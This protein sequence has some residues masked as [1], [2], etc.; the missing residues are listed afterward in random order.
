ML[1]EYSTQ[2]IL[3]GVAFVLL[4]VLG[5]YWYINNRRNQGSQEAFDIDAHLTSGAN[6]P[7]M[8]VEPNNINQERAPVCDE[9]GVCHMPNENDKS[10]M[11]SCINDEYADN[12][13]DAINIEQMTQNGELPVLP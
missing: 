10:D 8:S 11:M 9:N 3:A 6:D 7:M 4:I 5:V 2:Q 12:E 13:N 1:E